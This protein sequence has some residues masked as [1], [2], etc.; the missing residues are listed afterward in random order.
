LGRTAPQI[1]RCR[2]CRKNGKLAL[3]KLSPRFVVRRRNRRQQRDP[4]GQRHP[5]RADKTAPGSFELPELVQQDEVAALRDIG[6]HRCGGGKGADPIEV[7][8][9]HAGAQIVKDRT[10]RS[11]REVPQ[12]TGLRLPIRQP[13]AFRDKAGQLNVRPPPIGQLPKDFLNL[14]IARAANH[15]DDFCGLIHDPDG[16]KA[17]TIFAKTVLPRE[18]IGNGLRFSLR[19]APCAHICRYCLISE[20]RKRNALPFARFEQ[21]IHRFHDWRLSE[22]PDLDIGIFIGPSFDYDIETLKEVARLHE[23]R[24]GKFQIVNLA[25][26]THPTR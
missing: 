3:R 25:G 1:D 11:G 5:E 23:R 8:I 24:G 6:L 20:S 19:D 13:M 15:G 9:R 16:H 17:G 22:R 7:A 4:G 14:C 10:P 26:L 2:V 18:I 12:I 21:L